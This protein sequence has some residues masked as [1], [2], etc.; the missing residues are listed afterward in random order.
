MVPDF[1]TIRENALTIG[2]LLFF[3]VLIGITAAMWVVA[4]RTPKNIHPVDVDGTWQTIQQFYRDRPDRTTEVEL[5]NQWTSG[6]DPG[7]VFE[8]SWI[9]ATNELVALRH[10]AHPDLMMGGGVVSAIPM[11]IGKSH[12]TGMKVLAV[13]DLRQLHAL[14]PHRLEPAPD[15]LDQLTAS[16]GCPYEAPH[17]VDPQWPTSTG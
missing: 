2:S 3:A 8:L 14:H 9:R 12:A 13:V 4:N 16:L 7:A 5:G 15:G 10:Q 1:V 17:P 11:G 6:E